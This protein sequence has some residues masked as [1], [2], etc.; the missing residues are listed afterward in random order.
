MIVFARAGDKLN[1]ISELAKQLDEWS[2]AEKKHRAFVAVLGDSIDSAKEAATNLS[3]SLELKTV[4][5]VVPNEVKN[6]PETYEL[7]SDQQVTALI[8]KRGRV[9]AVVQ[10]TGD[11]DASALAKSIMDSVTA[12]LK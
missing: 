5:I 7:T 8:V 6:G 2:S 10:D 1:N 11:K 9:K 3:D 12:E 4:P